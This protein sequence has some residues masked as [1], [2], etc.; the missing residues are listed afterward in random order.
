MM[1]M[2]HRSCRVILS[3][4]R[5]LPHPGLGRL[6]GSGRF[7]VIES[8]TTGRR[9]NGSSSSSSSSSTT[10]S[11]ATTTTRITSTKVDPVVTAAP[12]DCETNLKWTD[13]KEAPWMLTKMA[14]PKGG[15]EPP[16]AKFLAFAA[17]VGAAGFYAW[18]IEPPTPKR[19]EEPVPT[20]DN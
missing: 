17:L 20:T 14:P 19:Y 8:S 15:T 6:S 10:T 3:R 5:R 4:Q 13:K 16:D 7:F 11:P 12:V 2:M 18:F 1:M 9:N